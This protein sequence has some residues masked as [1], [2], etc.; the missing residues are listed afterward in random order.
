[1]PARHSA[2]PPTDLR[3]LER[4][5]RY[6]FRQT[7]LLR[8]ALT[9]SSAI[10]VDQERRQPRPIGTAGV[11]GETST[12]RG[13][14]QDNERLEFLGD[15]V[16]GLAISGWLYRQYPL[17][18]EGDLT[19]LKSYLVSQPVLEAVGTALELDEYIQ[20]EPA[21]GGARIPVQAS[22]LA[23]AFEAV[24]G[25]LYLDGGWPP[26][27]RTIVRLFQPHL[28]RI[29]SGDWPVDAKSVLQEMAL[30][31]F[32]VTPH[33]RV[34][35][36]H[37]PEHAKSFTIAVEIRGRTYGTGTGSSKKRAEQAAAE[38]TLRAFRVKRKS[39]R[40]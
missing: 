23:G 27:E 14:S 1:M 22:M 18:Q 11:G 16:L 13:Q 32:A 36:E 8:L 40:H 4:A 2:P 31:R 5:L 28:V 9:H 20:R 39:P 38:Q 10:Q 26:A 24:V 17:L 34:I 21:A 6:R 7:A 29:R 33:Y 35:E 19:K 37:G 12:E 3:R 25:A 30:Q 15:T